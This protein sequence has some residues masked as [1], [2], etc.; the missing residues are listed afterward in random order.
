VIAT[1]ESQLVLLVMSISVSI[2]DSDTGQ[3]LVGD[4]SGIIDFFINFQE[5]I[6][7]KVITI[8][9]EQVYYCRYVILYYLFGNSAINIV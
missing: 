9:D 1:L 5:E 8:L 3:I 4:N 2:I 6:I 7:W